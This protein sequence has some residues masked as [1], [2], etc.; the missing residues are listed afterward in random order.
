M[1]KEWVAVA[2]DGE[3][4]TLLGEMLGKDPSILFL[5][6]FS[7]ALNFGK[8]PRVPLA[9]WTSKWEPTLPTIISLHDASEEVLKECQVEERLVGYSGVGES[10]SSYTFA[11]TVLHEREGVVVE[12]YE[13][14]S[15]HQKNKM[16]DDSILD[17][18]RADLRNK[19]WGRAFREVGV[20]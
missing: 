11:Y 7:H 14:S 3:E 19:V 18:I 16:L 17:G 13:A 10:T 4:L 20:I 1:N 2:S 5:T 15:V 6:D 12:R 8:M 9:A